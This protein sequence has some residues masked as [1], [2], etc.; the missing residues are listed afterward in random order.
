MIKEGNYI[1]LETQAIW[2][3]YGASFKGFAPELP[4]GF[5]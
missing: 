4:K 3:R 2:D 1:L 5:N